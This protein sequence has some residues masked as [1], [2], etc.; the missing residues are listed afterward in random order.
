MNSTIESSLRGRTIES[1]LRG[2][3]LLDDPSLNKGTAFDDDER[4]SLG[5]VGLLPDAVEELSDQLIRTKFEFDKLHDDL[6]RH[7]FLRQLQDHNEVLFFGF[8]QA[9]LEET[10]PIV[11]TPTVGLATQKFS[12]IFRRSHGLFLSYRSRETMQQQIDAIERDISVIVVTDGERILGLGDQGVGGMGIPNGKLSLYTAFGGIDPATTLPVILDVGTN[13]QDL[14][15]DE[16]Y[17]GYRANRVTGSEYDDFVEEFVSLVKKRWPHVLLQWED[18]AQ[19]N[20]NRILARYQDEILSFNDD[21]QGTAAVALAAIW[22]AVKKSGQTMAK[23]RFVIVGAGSAGTGI[24]KM[25]R[26]A[27]IDEGV[28][29]PLE[30]LYLVDRTGIVHDGQSDLADHQIELAHPESHLESWNGAAENPTLEQ[31]VRGTGATVLLGVSG[32]PG[33]FTEEAVRAMTNHTHAP[34]VMPMSNPTSRAEATPANVIKWTDGAAI[35]ATGSPFDPVTHNGVVHHISQANNVYVFP[36]VGLGTVATKT[37]K[38]SKAMLMA[39]AKA[40]ASPD[41]GPESPVLPALEEVPEVSVRIA[42]AVAQVAR[43]EGLTDVKTDDEIEA[44]IE[45]TRWMPVYPKI[46]AR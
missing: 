46:V 21:I 15:D 31:I 1:S 25:I 5:L 44:N 12:R 34:I 2:R 29:Q 45:E 6:E 42:R 7:I 18:F 16:W 3:Q 40:V 33:L 11:Y 13:N 19:Q 14:L 28:E 22:A 37:T 20:A 26:D 41:A 17:L 35:V 8:V 43:D 23:Q 4:S 32:Q 39:A 9:H 10:L 27:L 30:H 38:V 24:G 36:G